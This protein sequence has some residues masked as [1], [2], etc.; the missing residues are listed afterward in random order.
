[1]P[2]TLLLLLLLDSVRGLLI[3]LLVSEALLLPASEVRPLLGNCKCSITQFNRVTNSLHPSSLG[4]SLVAVSVA[5][6]TVLHT[7]RC[8]KELKQQQGCIA[9]TGMRLGNTGLC[10][11]LQD[12]R[13]VLTEI[14]CE[15]T[16]QSCC[17]VACSASLS[18]PVCSCPAL[19]TDLLLQYSLYCLR[20]ILTWL[21]GI[22]LRKQGCTYRSDVCVVTQ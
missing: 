7:G 14:G 13:W 6:S 19:H 21:T 17:C 10:T 20:S 8:C 16:A 12:T 15:G 1:M 3:V 5:M 4:S 2:S 11:A 22:L 9:D 18:L